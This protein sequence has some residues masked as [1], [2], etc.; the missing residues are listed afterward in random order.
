MN[1]RRREFLLGVASAALA[2]DML[3]ADV[4][5]EAYYQGS[6]PSAEDYY[7]PAPRVPAAAPVKPAVVRRKVTFFSP[8]WCSGCQQLERA[9]AGDATFDITWVHDE[10]QFPPWVREII[11]RGLTY[12]VAY[13]QV[14]ATVWRRM[15]G[16]TSVQAFKEHFHDCDRNPTLNTKPAP[17]KSHGALYYGTY[18]SVYDW[19][20]DLRQ[21]LTHAPHGYDSSYVASLTDGQC[22]QVHDGDHLRWSAHGRRRS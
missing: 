22:I 17:A 2:P 9:F 12:P 5:R 14:D 4:P 18:Q 21:H 16:V 10:K 11:S 6:P 20:G 1:I 7:R 15:A 13:W 3:L 8:S 19:P